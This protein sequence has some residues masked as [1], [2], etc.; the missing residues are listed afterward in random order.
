MPKP[1]YKS[2]Y[3]KVNFSM[4]LSPSIY[5]NLL[6]PNWYNKKFI[7]NALKRK[8]IFTNKKV[9]DFGCGTGS[10]CF[11][12]K[13][14]NYLGIDISQKRINYAKY[15]Y[16]EYQFDIYNN[17]KINTADNSIDLILLIAVLHHIHS[18]HIEDIFKEFK[19]ILKYPS[20][21]VIVLEPCFLKKHLIRN[22]FMKLF[23]RGKYIMM[24]EEYLKLFNNQA[25]EVRHIEIITK[26]AYKEIFFSA[27]QI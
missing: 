15:S 6:R 5:N 22:Y 7:V 25:F 17:D 9:L 27:Y 10:N 1:V 20:G 2:Y 23:D 12:C 4:E 3:K 19:R 14:K 21:I 13:P 8:Y 16:P 11:L 18:K 26:L 24:K